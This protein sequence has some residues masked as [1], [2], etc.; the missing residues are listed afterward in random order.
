MRILCDNCGAPQ[1]PDDLE[2]IGKNW[3]FEP[4]SIVPHGQCRECGGYCYEEEEPKAIPA[5][6]LARALES[7]TSLLSEEQRRE[8]LETGEVTFQLKPN[9][10][11]RKIPIHISIPAKEPPK[12]PE[13]VLTRDDL[14]SCVGKNP[15]LTELL[16]KQ[17]S[18]EALTALA[19][20]MDKKWM[21][22]KGWKIAATDKRSDELWKQMQ[23]FAK[24]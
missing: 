9:Y 12:S 11:L 7:L 5:D 17:V 6:F 10:P 21:A 1:D 20:E 13:F 8:F 22:E 23:L 16:E 18:D 14:K 24:K 3:H 2:P 4:G 15:A 19:K